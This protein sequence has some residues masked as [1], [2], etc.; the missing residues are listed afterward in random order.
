MKLLCKRKSLKY[1]IIWLLFIIMTTIW[2]VNTWDVN[3]CDCDEP[4]PTIIGYWV[5]YTL[6]SLMLTS[7]VSK[8]YWIVVYRWMRKH[9]K[10]EKAGH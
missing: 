5:G 7:P 8:I 4:Q 10:K 2:F 3:G 1:W 9:N 6:L